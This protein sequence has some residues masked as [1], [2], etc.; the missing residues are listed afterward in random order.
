MNVA[1][2]VFG[3]IYLLGATANIALVTIN[4]SQ[5]YAGL[6]DRVTKHKGMRL[7]NPL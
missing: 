5:S 2:I 1:R 4:G 7:I 3:I 6:A